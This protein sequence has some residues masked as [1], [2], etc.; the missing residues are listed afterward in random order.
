[1]AVQLAP[2]TP[3]SEQQEQL[4]GRT[5]VLWATEDQVASFVASANDDVIICRERGRHFFKGV[6]RGGSLKFTGINREG[7]HVRRIVCDDCVCVERV[8]LWELLHKRGK[9]YRAN[10]VAAHLD[11]LDPTYLGEPG[12]GRMK[13][14]QVREA[15]V[16]L[17]LTGQSFREL[18]KEI[19][20]RTA[21]ATSQPEQPAPQEE[22]EPTAEHASTG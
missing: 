8:E 20:A 12:Q 13:T 19:M 7:L 9:I 16:T 11:Y 6:G 1:M 15:L 17:A 22:P 4:D 5:P 14:K 10:L 18:R 2:P 21:T 3:V